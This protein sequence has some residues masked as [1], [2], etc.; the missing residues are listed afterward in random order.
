VQRQVDAVV[1]QAALWKI[2][3][4]D[5]LAAV[6]GADLQAARLG[7]GRGLL[8]AL[9]VEQARL[10]Q[11][12]RAG[13]VLVLAALVLA[14]DDDAGRQVRDADRRVGLVD[15][16]AASAGGAER[17]DL[18]VGIAQLDVLDLVHFRQDRDGRRRGVDASLGLGLRHALH[19]MRA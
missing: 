12:Q 17:V 9:L 8:R 18:E 11:R 15:V 16:L 10:E 13:A 4:T 1:G 3:R 19:A 7:L 5:A 6:A 2:I 14:L